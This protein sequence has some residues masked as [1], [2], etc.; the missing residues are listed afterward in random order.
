MSNNYFRYT[1]QNCPVCSKSFSAD[2]DIVVCPLC[3]TPHHREC[4]K[5]NG[6]C[7][8]YDK[9]NEG[10]RWSPTETETVEGPTETVQET[11]ENPV[12]NEQNIPVPPLFGTGVNPLSQFP[13]QIEEDVETAEVADFVQMNSIKYLQNFFSG[14]VNKKSFNWA[15]FFFTPYW[16]F[17]RKLY[18]L[19]A[20][21][22]AITLLL[23]VGFSFVPSVQKLYT[24]MAEWTEKYQIE[25]AEDLSE[26]ELMAAYEEQSAFILENKTGA[27]LIF[28]QGAL[29][30]ALQIF[31]GFKAN[32][33]YYD[34]TISNIRRIKKETTDPNQLRLLYFKSG[35]CST[36]AAF[37]AILANNMIVMSLEMLLTIIK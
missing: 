2:D 21:F 20:I 18:K 10:F 32:K 9:H 30:L 6:E 25:D 12:F 33:W 1:N 22:L 26:E 28:V 24:D 7:G 34:H 8:N 11:Q 36:G 5:Q 15:A 29:S 14:K 23:S 17:Y 13:K 35:G 27:V 4:Y 3:G 37:L 16:F 31:I 19:G